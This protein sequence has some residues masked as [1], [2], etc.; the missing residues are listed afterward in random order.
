MN[1]TQQPNQSND[2][3]LYIDRQDPSLQPTLRMIRNIVHTTAPGV[4]ESL[5]Y[6]M[7]AYKYRGKP[8][9]YFASFKNH[10]GVYPTPSAISALISDL[11]PYH[12]AKGSIQF[13]Y[14][15]PFPVD[16]LV[17]L[18]KYKVQEISSNLH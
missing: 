16:L 9:I 3:D 13:P 6:G 5:S 10:I 1:M 4:I 14:T 8:L 12:T 17:K 18:I 2:I 15:K 11:A 7:P